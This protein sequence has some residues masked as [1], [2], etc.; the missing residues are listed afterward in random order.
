MTRHV[1]I[2]ND[3]GSSE[4]SVQGWVHALSKEAQHRQQLVT[5]T[6]AEDVAHHLTRQPAHCTTLLMPGGFDKGFQRCIKRETISLIRCVVSAG[7][8]Y[9]SSCAGAYFASSKCIF[10]PQDG[11][12][13]V[14][15]ERALSLFPRAAYGA[16]RPHFAYN[17]ESGATVERLQV[18]YQGTRFSAAVYCNGAP[19]WDVEQGGALDEHVVA[20]YE[21]AVLLRHG[22]PNERPAAVIAAPFGT[23]V[24]VLSGVHAELPT[25]RDRARVQ[26]LHVL[27][28]AARV[29]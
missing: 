6:S 10:E 7:A 2:Y 22:V 5:L 8:S 1:Y 3:E 24:A 9:L 14:V 18:S 17:S 13:R 15:E 11:L 20:R 26:L 28:R 29:L 27:L 19:G 16:I 4:E 12:L 23:G 25:V 21:E